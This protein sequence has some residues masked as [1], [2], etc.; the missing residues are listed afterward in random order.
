MGRP[1]GTIA[2]NRTSARQLRIVR[3][4]WRGTQWVL[5]GYSQG[6]VGWPKLARAAGQGRGQAESACD[7]RAEGEARVPEVARLGLPCGRY[8]ALCC[9]G[10]D[11]PG[12]KAEWLVAQVR[13]ST[14]PWRKH[15]MMP[16][17][18]S[19]RCRI[20]VRRDV[21]VTL[22]CDAYCLPH[23]ELRIA[24]CRICIGAGLAAATLGRGEP[25]P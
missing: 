10:S 25:S 13:L 14:R 18:A 15:G 11:G 1:S 23:C 12:R 17:A 9:M 21:H 8:P 24:P 19:G 2:P 5:T 7:R 3:W 20:F 6:C 22:R 16:C 4:N